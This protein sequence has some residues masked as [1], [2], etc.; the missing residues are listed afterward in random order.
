MTAEVLAVAMT[1][2]AA[3]IWH[4][5]VEGD[6]GIDPTYD[7]MTWKDSAALEMRPSRTA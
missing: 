4:A 6:S 1:Y 7:W 5:S 2:G 3:K